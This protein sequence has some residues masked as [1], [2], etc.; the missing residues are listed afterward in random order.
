M[1]DR[2]APGTALRVRSRPGVPPAVRAVEVDHLIEPRK[3]AS[4]VF[5]LEGRH[6]SLTVEGSAARLSDLGSKNGTFVDEI[7]ID[8]PTALRDGARLR[9]GTLEL[10]YRSAVGGSSTDTV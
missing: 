8:Q 9:F 4:T 1:I 5:R 3:V 2:T 10:T 6:A 7:K